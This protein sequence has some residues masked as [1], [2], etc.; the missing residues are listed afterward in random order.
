M[1]DKVNQTCAMEFKEYD[2]RN[3]YPTTIDQVAKALIKHKPDNRKKDPTTPRPT[4]SA[5]TAS[6]SAPD[7][8]TE[9]SDPG[10]YSDAPTTTTTTSRRA[11]RANLQVPATAS[12]AQ[13]DAASSV[14]GTQS[15][16][17]QHR[18][19]MQR[20]VVDRS[21]NGNSGTTDVTGSYVVRGRSVGDGRSDGR[22]TGWN[23]AQVCVRPILKK[24]AVSTEDRGELLMKKWQA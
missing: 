22:I 16:G 10:R 17:Q 15:T 9:W 11:G 21:G 6:S 14:T 3:E 13:S 7:G 2:Q 18:S 5:T 8:V 1:L 23:L 19:N 12:A 20:A 4:P 24:K